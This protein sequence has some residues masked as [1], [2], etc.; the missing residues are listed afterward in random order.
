M[1][2][3]TSN[4]LMI[5]LLIIL[6]VENLSTYINNPMKLA[7]LLISIPGILI[8][9]TFHEYAHALAADKL[10]DD[11]PRRNGRLSLN[12]L[13]H[14][15]PYGAILMLTLGFGWGKPVTINPNNFKR[16]I[17]IRKGNAIVAIAG[18]LMNF[19]LAI[20]FSIILGL[21][22]RFQFSFLAT[23]VRIYNRKYD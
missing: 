5:A 23:K 22:Y 2:F 20:V 6:I 9:I 19:I 18:P 1:Y 7:G 12:P 8:A 4:P 10:G 21:L 13:H 3:D 17:S 14:L 15:D 11:T 16:N